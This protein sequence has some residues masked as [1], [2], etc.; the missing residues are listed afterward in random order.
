MRERICEGLDHM[1]IRIDPAKNTG[2]GG[3]YFSIHH[4]DSPIKVL[5]VATDEEVQIARQ[6][7]EVIKDS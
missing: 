3:R 2:Q 4:H 1:G 5:V 7:R 6:T